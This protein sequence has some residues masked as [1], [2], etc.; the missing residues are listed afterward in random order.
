MLVSAP[1]DYDARDFLIHVYLRLC[2]TV[3]DLTG[4][5][6]R[7]RIVPALSVL[8]GLALV[9]WQLGWPEVAPPRP[10]VREGLL[11]LGVALVAAGLGYRRLVR[12]RADDRGRSL[13]ERARHR[14]EQLRYVRTYTTGHSVGASGGGLEWARSTGRQLAEQPLTLPELVA[15]YREFVEAA[16]AWWRRR[17]P[18]GRLVVGIDEVDRIADPAKV[19][20]FVND[21]KAMFGT[22]D[23]VY[24]VTVSDE[25]LSSV[26]GRA[27][28]ARTA[29]DSTFEELVRVPA[30]DLPTAV[31]LV[32]R[33]VVGLPYPFLLLCH[34]LAAG[35]PRELI[36]VA[37]RI[38]A[39]R[40]ETRRNE[41]AAIARHVLLADAR[42]AHA[43]LL[44]PFA[45]VPGADA[46]LAL[47]DG[48]AGPADVL[49]GLR[50][51]EPELAAA[52]D[53]LDAG[54]RV[55]ATL[56]D[57]FSRRADEVAALFAAPPETPPPA[58]P[59][60]S[61]LRPY[62]AGEGRIGFSYNGIRYE[63]DASGGY[64]GVDEAES[65][66][67]PPPPDPRTALLPAIGELF[68]P[69]VA[70][71]DAAWRQPDRARD[72]LARFTDRAGSGALRV[73]PRSVGTQ[74]KREGPPVVLPVP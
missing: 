57:V 24:L 11:A 45:A 22:R 33:R 17:S 32:Q 69:L 6:R 18:T 73:D 16:T 60:L 51:D 34:C 54:W 14:L 56:L 37:R 61:A 70:A 63:Q 41:L 68:E 21:L 5:R 28:G 55:T 29:L 9:G 30:M 7:L 25:A 1:V 4:R 39:A 12:R 23:C 52:V 48:A 74:G 40:R 53:R 35:L 20:R 3:R 58:D 49:R 36:R 71:R 65:G 47:P 66:P 62:E 64:V 44:S 26:E 59:W 8:A 38:V 43:S 2:E 27:R 31:A 15:S 46:L 13:A 10:T 50:T 19:E 42:A 67:P 72:A